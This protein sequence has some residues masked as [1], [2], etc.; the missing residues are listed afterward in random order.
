MLALGGYVSST[1]GDAEQPSS[2]VTAI[3]IGFSVIPAL[4]TL[5]SL[6]FLRRYTLDISVVEEFA[7]QS[8]RNPEEV[9]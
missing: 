4:L 3:V 7:Q 8:S 6:V 9:P 5:L 2:A 1:T